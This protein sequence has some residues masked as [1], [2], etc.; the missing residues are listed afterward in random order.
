M[1]EHVNRVLNYSL[2]FLVGERFGRYSKYVIQER[3]LPDARDGL[4]PVQRRILY[5]MH[6]DGNTAAKAFRKSAKTVGTVIGNYHPHGDSSVYEAMVRLSQW[7]KM[8]EPLIEMHGNNGS[9]DDDP[10]AAMRYTEARLSKLSGLLLQ[11][12]DK[13]TILWSPNFDDTTLEPTVLPARF[14]NLL[15]NG[16]RGIA[17]GYATFIPTHNLSEVIKATIHRIKNPECSLDEIITLMPG[18]DFPTGGIVRGKEGIR[19]AYETGSGSFQVESK[20]EI[21]DVKGMMSIV[22]SELPYEVVKSTLV[23]TIDKMRIDRTIDGILEVRDES[24]RTGLRV[25]IELKKDADVKAIMTYLMKKTDLSSKYSYNMVAIVD[26]HPVQLG[27]IKLLDAYIH[28]Q[29]DVYVKKSQFDLAE[30]DRRTHIVDGLIIAISRIDEVIAVIRQ[31]TNKSTARAA[32]Q[33]LLGI[34]EEQAE[35]IVLLQLYRL[36]STDIVTLQKEQAE[37]HQTKEHLERLLAD[38]QLIA[39]AIIKDLKAVDKEFGSPRKSEL[40]DEALDYSRIEKPIT[41]EEAMVV[42]TRDGYLK[43]SSLKSYAASNGALPGLKTG[44]MVLAEVQANTIDTLLMFTD[45][46]NYM[47]LPVHQVV[48]TKWKDEGNHINSLITLPSDEKI[49]KVIVIKSFDPRLSIV[50][51]TEEG[52][53]KRTLLSEF[54]LSMFHKP[55]R[56]MNLGKH[57]RLVSA[58][59]TDGDSSLVVIT[60]HGFGIR[61]SEHQVSQIGIRTS[62]VKAI[63]KTRGDSVAGVVAVRHDHPGLILLISDN[64]AV[65]FIKM[66]QLP[67]S[68]NRLGRPVEITRTFKTEPHL[69][70]YVIPFIH[71]ATRT[72]A[73]LEGH[74]FLSVQFKSLLPSPFGKILRREIGE[75]G[76]TEVIAVSRPGDT[77]VLTNQLPAFDPPPPSVK[78]VVVEGE[79]EADKVPTIFDYIDEEAE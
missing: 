61:Y 33:H 13:N 39:Q 26:K 41:K 28:H 9:M 46:G 34:D 20:F 79:E 29:Q 78:Q 71:E 76:D 5:A 17:S 16:A 56:C 12:I 45:R 77:L 37:L 23:A 67:L 73:M 1:S 52:Q 60:S 7:W 53:I 75:K 31:S 43:R 62:G 58:D 18:P 65:K 57:D 54:S 63:Q 27:V 8:G 55:V 10:P 11:D 22:I 66:E 25:V 72:D 24:D 44:D 36:S 51:A 74:P 64:G 40:R 48:E 6:V 59:I 42:V 68:N 30:I 35:A 47:A 3:A 69:L 4:K 15:V 32:V 38:P 50:L 2:E 14:P 70:R 49:L 19:Q 21:V